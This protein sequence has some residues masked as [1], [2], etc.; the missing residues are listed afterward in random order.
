MD[1]KISDS[2]P[3][4]T[5]LPSDA[6]QP[7]AAAVAESNEHGARTLS[8]KPHILIL[9]EEAGVRLGLGDLWAFRELLY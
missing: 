8:D 9:S 7:A 5:H 3:A 6:R 2:S 1:V 4:T